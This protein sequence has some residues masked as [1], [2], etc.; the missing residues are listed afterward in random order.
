MSIGII[1]PTDD[2][3]STVDV[4]VD[5]VITNITYSFRNLPV[6]CT[7]RFLPVQREGKEIHVVT[8]QALPDRCI[9]VKCDFPEDM[10][11]SVEDFIRLLLRKQVYVC[12]H[13]V[14][15]EFVDTFQYTEDLAE[16]ESPPT[17]YIV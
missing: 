6:G 12:E 13:L 9:R 11:Q 8:N 1:I 2:Q 10:N 3:S 16:Y 4:H 17:P 15:T 5:I 14:P 7:A